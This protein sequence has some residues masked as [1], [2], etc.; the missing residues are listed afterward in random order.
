[1]QKILFTLASLCLLASCSTIP[2]SSIISQDD[3]RKPWH[4]FNGQLSILEPSH[5]WQVLIHWQADLSSGKT[6]LTHAATGRI[7]EL[8]WHGKHIQI[9]NNQA[10][11]AA[12]KDINEDALMHYGIVLPPQTI[13]A[14]LYHHI[15]P[16]L[17]P[18]QNNTW[19]GSLHGNNIRLRWQNNYHKLTMTDISHGR[20][21]ILR[22]FP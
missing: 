13:A 14:I 19:Q 1:M 21:A 11:N 2:P 12:W 18:T 6:R 20:T 9:R 16:S 5:R 8:Q 17:K 7:I 10:D 3:E 4:S 22:I 15:P